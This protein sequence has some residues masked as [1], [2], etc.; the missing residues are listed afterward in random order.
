MTN[1]ETPKDQSTFSG[2]AIKPE[3]EKHQVLVQVSALPK[4]P[5]SG[6]TQPAH[7]KG[8]QAGAAHWW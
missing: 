7:G 4:Q 2:T 5:L 1:N 6:L 3:T 8:M